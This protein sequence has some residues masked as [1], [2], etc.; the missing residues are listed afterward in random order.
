M[1]KSRGGNAGG[2]MRARIAGT[3]S[4][5]AAAGRAAYA[6]RR[7]TPASGAV[8]PTATPAATSFTKFRRLELIRVDS[9]FCR[10]GGERLRAHRVEPR[11]E[12]LDDGERRHVGG[13]A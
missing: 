1:A 6:T 8:A 4:Q 7:A 12:E 2:R 5:G 9:L 3:W 13:T 11:C 10:T